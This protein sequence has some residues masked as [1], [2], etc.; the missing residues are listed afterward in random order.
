VP[1]DQGKRV[2]PE[3][4][5]L[6]KQKVPKGSED[7]LVFTQTANAGTG[8]HLKADPQQQGGE[9]IAR[10]SRGFRTTAETAKQAVATKSLCRTARHPIVTPHV[11]KRLLQT[12]CQAGVWG[13]GRRGGGG[14]RGRIWPA[15]E[16]RDIGASATTF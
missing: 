10:F 2:E 5:K 15:G 3:S 9:Q 14:G 12:N 1:L 4:V 6:Q 8:F 16:D 13:G 11:C 7:V